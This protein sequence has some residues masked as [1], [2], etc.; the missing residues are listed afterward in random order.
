MIH[1][2]I[3]LSQVIFL[4]RKKRDMT[5][6]LCSLFRYSHI[7]CSSFWRKEVPCKFL[8]LTVFPVFRSKIEDEALLITK[9]PLYFPVGNKQEG[10]ADCTILV[11]TRWHWSSGVLFANLTLFWPGSRIV[12]MFNPM[13]SLN[14][15]RWEKGANFR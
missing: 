9:L 2:Y 10:R 7:I 14:V 1:R 4:S 12:R 15:W 13:V 11:W 8:M 3:T 5:D 6:K